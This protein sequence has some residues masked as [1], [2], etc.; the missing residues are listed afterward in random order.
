MYILIDGFKDAIHPLGKEPL[1]AILTFCDHIRKGI[2]YPKGLIAGT[3]EV[4]EKCVVDGTELELF[5]LVDRVSICF[6]KCE[7]K[8]EESLRRV[9]R[10]R[11]V[12]RPPCRLCRH[13][14]GHG[15]YCE[16]GFSEQSAWAPVCSDW[17]P[18]EVHWPDVDPTHPPTELYEHALEKRIYWFLR[19]TRTPVSV[20][21]ITEQFADFESVVVR[22]AVLHLYYNG[23]IE[24]AD[25]PGDVGIPDKF[26]ARPGRYRE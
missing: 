22:A 18:K 7:G 23:D 6:N 16:T 2:G 26:R 9:F 19:H 1:E 14:K 21:A 4:F 25:E 3:T 5:V 13:W 20:D 17:Q 15:V 8:R 10:I 11:K 24:G 12:P